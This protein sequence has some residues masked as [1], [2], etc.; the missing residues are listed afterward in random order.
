MAGIRD[1]QIIISVTGLVLR[2]SSPNIRS[3]LLQYG[4]ERVCDAK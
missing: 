1:A 2:A 4:G 3:L